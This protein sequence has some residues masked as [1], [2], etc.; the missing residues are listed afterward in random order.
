M[1]IEEKI[2]GLQ[3]SVYDVHCVHLFDPSDYL[4]EKAASFSFLHTSTCNN[5]VEQLAPTRILHDEI[6]LFSSLD[7]LVEL[8]H[9]RVSDELQDVHLSRDSLNI[10]HLHDSLLLEHL[11]GGAFSSQNVRS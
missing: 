3:I 6:Q 5:V 9:M 2:L 1:F 8:H 11:D 4:M 7:D 10:G